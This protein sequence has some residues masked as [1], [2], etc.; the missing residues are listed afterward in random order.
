MVTRV[1]RRN[2]DVVAMVLQ[3]GTHEAGT[4]ERRYA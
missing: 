4:V 2:D 1:R 3:A